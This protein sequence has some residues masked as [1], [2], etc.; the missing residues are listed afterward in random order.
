MTW[1]WNKYGESENMKRKAKYQRN[2]ILINIKMKWYQ[3]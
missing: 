3:Y 2:E 1:I